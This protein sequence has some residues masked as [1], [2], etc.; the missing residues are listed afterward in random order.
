MGQQL[1]P[2]CVW[3]LGHKTEFSRRFVTKEIAF[4]NAVSVL[5][6]LWK[7]KT[8]WTDGMKLEI[9]QCELY[10]NDT[11]KAWESFQEIFLW[12]ES[13]F[14]RKTHLR[15]CYENMLN[16]LWT[17]YID[18]TI[19]FFWLRVTVSKRS[20]SCPKRQNPHFRNNWLRGLHPAAFPS[21]LIIWWAMAQ[22]E[23]HR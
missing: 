13:T 8:L 2:Q 17:V 4:Q 14:E 7:R 21:S 12:V 5:W 11:F 20:L 9:H 23:M 1:V 6:T 10:S 18:L 19:S 3:W 22:W 15:M 16:I